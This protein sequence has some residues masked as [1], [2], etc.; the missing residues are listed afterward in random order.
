MNFINFSSKLNPLTIHCI[1]RQLEEVVYQTVMNVKLIAAYLFAYILCLETVLI[2]V[3]KLL[4]PVLILVA[5]LKYDG[6]KFKS[7]KTQYHNLF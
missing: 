5:I 2:D 4:F 3:D 1:S 7:I 6:Q